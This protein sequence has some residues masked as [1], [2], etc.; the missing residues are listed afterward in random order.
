VPLIVSS[1]RDE[2]TLRRLVD[3]EIGERVRAEGGS[4]SGIGDRSTLEAAAS[5]GQVAFDR[6]QLVTASGAVMVGPSAPVLL[7]LADR[8]ESGS[9]AFAGGDFHRMLSA[10]YRRGAETLIAFDL[11]TLMGRRRDLQFSG[12]AAPLLDAAGLGGLQHF[13]FRS[14][15]DELGSAVL[16]F[17]EDRKGLSSWLADPAPM[18][19]LEFVS[20]QATVLLSAVFKDPEAMLRDIQDIA[21]SAEFAEGLQEFRTATGIDPF[22]D[23]AA[24]LGGEMTIALDGPLFPTPAWKAV[25]EVYDPVTLQQTIESL[26]ARQGEWA[27]EQAVLNGEPLEGIRLVRQEGSKHESWMLRMEG[28]PTEVHYGFVDGYLVATG[29]AHRLD[30]AI[31][32]RKL[33]LSVLEAQAFTSVLPRDGEQHFSMIAWQNLGPALGLLIQGLGEMASGGQ[34]LPSISPAGLESACLLHARASDRD[35]AFSVSSEGAG[36]GA[37][38]AALLR[39]GLAEGLQHAAEQGLL[40]ATR[41]SPGYDEPSSP[42]EP[43]DASRTY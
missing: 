14:D 2:P 25:I 10:E 11:E 26:V 18:G 16:S 19:S 4:F 17:S 24:P 3:T 28:L 5:L 30:A 33:G 27:R 41:R 42:A 43:A 39:R 32:N 21:G 9:G 37:H 22:T 20:P 8:L 23:I 34:G 7:E 38:L 31:E 40:D 12:A 1:L 6:V 35:I 13:L 15:G 29:S 36:P